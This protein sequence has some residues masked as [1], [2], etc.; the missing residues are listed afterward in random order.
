[1]I[2]L[3]DIFSHTNKLHEATVR[4]SILQTEIYDTVELI[5]NK[6]DSWLLRLPKDLQNAPENL[7]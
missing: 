1:M 6:L 4:K 2:R 7:A 3:T 5:A